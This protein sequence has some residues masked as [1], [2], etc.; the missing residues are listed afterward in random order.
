MKYEL[1]KVIEDLSNNLVWIL[2]IATAIFTYIVL[3]I[4]F[5]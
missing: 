5:S 4:H 2:C 3:S 1:L